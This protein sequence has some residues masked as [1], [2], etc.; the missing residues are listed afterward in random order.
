V[1]VSSG[2]TFGALVL[3]LL[4]F[5]RR[6]PLP[7]VAFALLAASLALRLSGATVA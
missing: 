1:L 2:R 7:R 3:W 4:V 6:G 5:R